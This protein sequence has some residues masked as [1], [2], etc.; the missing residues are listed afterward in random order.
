[1]MNDE[2][3]L[4]K[5]IE[6]GNEMGDV[7]EEEVKTTIICSVECV[8]RSEDYAAAKHDMQP[9]IVLVINKL[10]YD[11]QSLVEYDEQKYNVMR[12]YEPK[13]RHNPTRMYIDRLELVCKGVD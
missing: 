5:T 6:T 4:I 9:E 1:M 3:T 11:N 2:L 13:G 12:R 10:D 7:I 8:T